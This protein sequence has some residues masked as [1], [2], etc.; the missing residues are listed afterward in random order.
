MSP[1]PERTNDAPVGLEWQTGGYTLKREPGDVGAWL[2]AR[3][4]G[5]LS[6][7]EDTDDQ[8]TELGRGRLDWDEEGIDDPATA[9]ADPEGS[10]EGDEDPRTVRIHRMPLSF[11]GESVIDPATVQHDSEEATRW[12]AEAS[13][14]EVPLLHRSPT[15]MRR[16]DAVPSVVRVPPASGPT[17]PARTN[18]AALTAT[19]VLGGGLG[20]IFVALWGWWML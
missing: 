3:I 2:A 13:I 15:P 7:D 1:S 11:I 17:E 5:Q 20:L 18:V 16:K 19:A 14:D 6:E 10:L 9:L 12:R 8:P 4:D